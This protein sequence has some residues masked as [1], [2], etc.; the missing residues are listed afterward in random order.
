MSAD[1]KEYSISNDVTPVHHGAKDVEGTRRADNILLAK[2][3]YRSEFK[4]EFSVSLFYDPCPLDTDTEPA[5]RDCGILLFHHGR[6]CLCDF[7]L[8]FPLICR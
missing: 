2:L 3:G 7:H 8:F 5:H 6:R 4:R 1:E